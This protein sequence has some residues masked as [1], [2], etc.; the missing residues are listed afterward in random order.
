[1]FSVPLDVLK[2][3]FGIFVTNAPVAGAQSLKIKQ[4]TASWVYSKT[5]MLQEIWE[6]QNQ[7]Q[8]VCCAYL[9]RIRLF[10]YHGP[11]KS[12]TAVSNI[13]TEAELFS[14]YAELRRALQHWICGDMYFDI[15]F[16]SWRRLR[17]CGLKTH[18]KTSERAIIQHAN[19]MIHLWNQRSCN[20]TIF[21]KKKR[22]SYKAS[23]ITHTSCWFRLALWSHQS[24]SNDPDQIR[25]H[26]RAHGDHSQETDG[27]NCQ[28]WWIE[29]FS[30][31]F[32]SF[33]CS[34]GPVFLQ[35]E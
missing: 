6:T 35:H 31:L 4:Q 19:F 10:Q 17:A 11:V 21:F 32:V 20:G 3:Y 16:P 26:N 25:Q 1:M 22:K 24:A 34:C 5:P 15:A 23:C 13:S 9:D 28:C 14:L 33:F 7:H 27:H 18:P 2:Q 8:E 30:K 29:S 12:Q